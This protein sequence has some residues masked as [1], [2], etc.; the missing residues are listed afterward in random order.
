MFDVEITVIVDNGA[1]MMFGADVG[2]PEVV[3]RVVVGGISF[4]QVLLFYL[5]MMTLVGV[6]WY[7]R[8]Y[9]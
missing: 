4:F 8:L 9:L 5:K 6:T 2:C 3:V 7:L 1:D